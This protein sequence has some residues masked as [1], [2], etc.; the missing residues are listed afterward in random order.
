MA[1]TITQA[2][3]LLTA[4][5]LELFDQSRA[6]PIKALTLARLRGK[7]TRTRTLRDKYRDLFR[8]QTVA[9]RSAPGTKS[10]SPVGADN[11][12]T[13]RKADILQEVLTRFEARV[14][15]LEARDTRE[16]AAATNAKPKAK[17]K[18]NVKAKTT[19]AQPVAASAKSAAAGTRSNQAKPAPGS[20]ATPTA[21]RSKAESG[22]SPSTRAGAKKSAEAKG[23]KPSA[24][25][26][27][28]GTAAK[29]DTKPVK[30]GPARASKAAT[31]KTSS[32]KT[33]V[34]HDSATATPHESAVPSLPERS[35]K[36]PSDRAPTTNGKAHAPQVNAPVDLV[37]AALRAN[38][39]KQ[40][41]G[42]M[43]IHA[44]QGGSTRR[45]QG[46]RDSR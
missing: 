19:G 31:A 44:H 30:S 22:A 10:R 37:P 13:Q 40:T 34:L 39:L 24:K 5:E 11:E 26:A 2:R 4:A 32:A 21:S 23:S 18:P 16:A 20:K 29:S 12:R 43:A 3:P 6:E 25:T 15:Q 46:K 38:P 45:A 36:A 9:V 1:T 7:V 35:L 28:A 41:A 33:S 27:K 8:R 42:N 17:A 14:A